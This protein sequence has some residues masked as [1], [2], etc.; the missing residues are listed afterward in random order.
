MLAL[1]ET[2]IAAVIHIGVKP[3]GHE[4]VLDLLMKQ[5]RAHLAEMGANKRDK[6]N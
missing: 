1:L 4:L 5:I 6:M 3:Q 2:V